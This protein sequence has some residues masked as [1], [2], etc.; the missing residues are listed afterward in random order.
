MKN[1][2]KKTILLF[3]KMS[4]DEEHIVEI[5]CKFCGAPID[6]S[7]DTIGFKCPYCGRINLD[8]SEKIRGYVKTPKSF[9]DI[10]IKNLIREFLIKRVG[11]E[12]EL[13]KIHPIAIP[14]WR[15]HVTGKCRYRGYKTS[16]VSHTKKV[17]GKTYVETHTV[18]IPVE[19]VREVDL[20]TP[21][22]GKVYMDVYALDEILE[23]ALEISDYT[24]TEK[25]IE[26]GWI[27]LNTEYKP[28]EAR[29]KIDDL[30]EDK[31][32]EWAEENMKEVFECS[33][34]IEIEALDLIL[35]PIILFTYLYKGKRYRGVADGVKK[36]ISRM[37]IPLKKR[38]REIYF[39]TGY[40]TLIASGL[41]GA[42]LNNDLSWL[43]AGLAGIA[44]PY[45]IWRA[46]ASEEIYD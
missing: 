1:I 27:A 5:K 43:F 3:M 20:Y 15:G 45:M 22:F 17:D 12:V 39:I 4:K 31:L 42:I 24:D 7:P 26:N 6:I 9:R 33:P 21:A 23:N 28:E 46:T 25:L 32:F 13:Y 35:Y 29:E 41:I 40:L 34:T 36:E 2:N 14:I 11:G 37:E 16:V 38:R 19:G 30:S 8:L 18:Y 10:D 44:P